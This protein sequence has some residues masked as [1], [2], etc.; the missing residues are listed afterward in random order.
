MQQMFLKNGTVL[1]TCGRLINTQNLV[2][3]L[4][5]SPTRMEDMQLVNTCKA[6]QTK[7]NSDSS[8]K[9]SCVLSAADGAEWWGN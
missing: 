2:M 7:H 9:Y 4:A 5:A 6:N 8:K 1:G 3:A